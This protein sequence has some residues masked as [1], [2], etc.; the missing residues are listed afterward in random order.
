MRWNGREWRVKISSYS[1]HHVLQQFLPEI[2]SHQP[3]QSST[4][5]TLCNFALA[6]KTDGIN[7]MLRYVQMRSTALI[8]RFKWSVCGQVQA[9]YCTLYCDRKCLAVPR[10]RC[11]AAGLVKEFPRKDDSRQPS[12]GSCLCSVK[13]LRDIPPRTPDP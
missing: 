8:D 3:L 4:S 7:L 1:E 5:T 6:T 10:F 2:N 13:K 11:T 9:T 12:L